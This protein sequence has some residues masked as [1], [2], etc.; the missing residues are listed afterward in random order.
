M[1][2]TTTKTC[3]KHA[4]LFAAH[5]EWAVRIALGIFRKRAKRRA[6]DDDGNDRHDY[7]QM[8]LVALLTTIPEYRKSQGGFE[9][10]AWKRVRG[11]IIQQLRDIDEVG[12]SQRAKGVRHPRTVLDHPVM[13]D[14][15]MRLV[16]FK[17]LIQAPDGASRRDAFD[18]LAAILFGLH[19]VQRAVVFLTIVCEYSDATMACVLG[20]TQRRVA[21][22]RSD[23][24]A[25]LARQ[26]RPRRGPPRRPSDPPRPPVQLELFED[27]S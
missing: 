12:R 4:E 23:G 21:E 17:D 6:R 1:T 13:G 27:P 22:L 24:M 14:D 15:S 25:Y 19:A 2:V 3:K 11:R 8:A 16:A 5:R 10:F 9:P 20:I 26:G 18:S 7:E